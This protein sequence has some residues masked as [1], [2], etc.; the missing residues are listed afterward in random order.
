VPDEHHITVD[1]VKGL[2][3]ASGVR[4]QIAEWTAI[5]A[6]PGQIESRTRN[7]RGED[8]GEHTFPGPG[9]VPRSMDQDDRPLHAPK[10]SEIDHSISAAVEADLPAVVASVPIGSIEHGSPR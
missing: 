6:V 1:V 8:Q 2:T 7:S 5:L 9:A 10:P 4:V 3:H